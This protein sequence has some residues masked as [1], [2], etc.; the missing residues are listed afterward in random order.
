MTALPR[1]AVGPKFMK[2]AQQWPAAALPQFELVSFEEAF[3]RE[4]DFDAHFVTYD[5]PTLETFPRLRKVGTT[6]EDLRKAGHTVYQTMHALDYDTPGH[7]PWEPEQLIEFR[8]RVETAG[9]LD[10]MLVAWQVYYATRAGA[11]FVYVLKDPIPVGPESEAM[12]RSLV[13]AWGQRGIELDPACSD[14][15]RYFRLPKVVRE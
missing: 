8:T 1:V 12:H 13:R 2:G 3:E 5:V 14:W 7:T 6:L 11:R 10:S 9:A 4:W 15:T